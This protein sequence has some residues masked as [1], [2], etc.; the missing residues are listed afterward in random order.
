MAA[1]AASVVTSACGERCGAT[2]AMCAAP[3][4][5]DLVLTEADSGKAGV[6]LDR[7]VAFLLDGHRDRLF[8]SPA[9]TVMTVDD[10]FKQFPNRHAFAIV[11]AHVG[12]FE[13]TATGSGL[14]SFT[15]HLVV[16]RRLSP[17]SGYP[18]INVL[19]RG[20]LVVQEYP[21]AYAP[22]PLRSP[23]FEL[24]QDAVTVGTEGGLLS[25]APAP[26]RRA[27]RAVQLGAQLDSTTHFDINSRAADVYRVV[28][29]AAP[30]D[31]LFVDA[32]APVPQP[33]GVGAGSRFGIVLAGDRRQLSWSALPDY[34]IV[35]LPD[36]DIG[37][38]PP[39]AT[40]V[41][42]RALVEGKTTLQIQTASRTI[43]IALGVGGLSCLP[44]DFPRYPLAH[45]GSSTFSGPCH[46]DMSS[47]D[48]PA[49]VLAFY[50]LHLT[51][52]DWRVV[53]ASGSVVKFARLSD[54]TFSGT[55]TVDGGAIHIHMNK[56]LK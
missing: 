53:S 39:G 26:T 16:G 43:T 6:S 32:E 55:V 51:E 9:S 34:G 23:T 18:G 11:T 2:G 3:P 52:G 54:S 21:L 19:K 41:P 25:D 29:A 33:I 36:P 22:L 10:P 5:Y 50:R 45:W 27:Y 40:L 46:V 28:V 24:V 42:F 8:T 44:D 7:G 31:F 13:V 15:F 37:P 1:I 4:S 56:E 47:P 49:K 14:A 35:R 17:Q 30:P 38:Q 48:P 12:V 20:D